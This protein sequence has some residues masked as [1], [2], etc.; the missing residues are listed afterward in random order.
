[1]NDRLIEAGICYGMK[2]NEGKSQVNAN[3]KVTNPSTDYDRS[4]TTAKC[5]I[6]QIPGQPGNR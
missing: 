1:M 6:F 4:K 3:L 2:M 5:R